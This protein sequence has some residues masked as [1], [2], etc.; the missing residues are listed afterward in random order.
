MGSSGHRDD[1]WTIGPDAP[2]DQ[3]TRVT[4]NPDVGKARNLRVGDR[5][6]VDQLFSKRPETTPENDPHERGFGDSLEG[7]RGFEGRI[8]WL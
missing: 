7:F 3:A 1:P 2:N 4:D 5:L 6:C 8:I